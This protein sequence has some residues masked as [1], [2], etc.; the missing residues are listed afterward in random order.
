MKFIQMSQAWFKPSESQICDPY[1][2]GLFVAYSVFMFDLGI[3]WQQFGTK[4]VHS[5]THSHRYDNQYRTN[6]TIKRWKA[7]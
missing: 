3:T 1:F 5:T 2:T 6:D 7:Q 4:I